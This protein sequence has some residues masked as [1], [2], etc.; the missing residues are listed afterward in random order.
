[1]PRNK[2]IPCESGIYHVTARGVGQQVIFEDDA[3]RKHFG[4]LMR[5]YLVEHGV[6][7]YAW[8]FMQNHIHLLLFCSLELLS[9][10]MHQLLGNYAQ[11]YNWRYQR[12]GHLFQ[13]RFASKPVLDE[14]R[15]LATVRYIHQ[16]PCDLDVVNLSV[17]TWSSYREYVGRPF[18]TSC[19]LVLELFGG[20]EE[21][22][23]AHETI[24]T[25]ET[26]EPVINKEA[27][28]AKTDDDAIVRAKELLGCESLAEIAAADKAARDSMLVVLKDSGMSVRQIARIT[29]ISKSVVQR[30]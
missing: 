29:G 18:I 30:A 3:D 28:R 6:A 15:L 25:D 10:S 20:V 24:E 11:Y 21:F 27:K 2:R 8:C 4:Q 5:K 23:H 26:L 16:N 13:G 14:R 7:L 17:Y 9:T 1:M 19:G 12:T 22:I